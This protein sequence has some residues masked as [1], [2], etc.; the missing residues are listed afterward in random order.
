MGMRQQTFTNYEGFLDKF[1]PKK[2]TDDC[3]TP[4]NV[5]E[6]VKAWAVAEYGLE[7]REIVRPFWPGKD[8]EMAEYP[9]G[10]VVID[11]PP[12]SIL[13]KIVRWFNA[14]K[15]DYFLFA[16]YLTNFSTGELC[17]HI[18]APCSVRYANG[19]EIPTSF[20]TNLGEC[21][22]RTAPSLM[23]AIA[24]ANAENLD[25]K[26]RVLPKY[27]YPAEVITS[28]AVGQLCSHGY[29]FS[30]RR[31]ECVHIRSLDAQGDRTLF[32]AGFLMSAAKA[33][34]REAAEREAAEREAA[35]NEMVWKLSP[36]E[37]EVVKMLGRRQRR[38]E[39]ENANGV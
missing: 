38:D 17:N 29:E 2:T 11:N 1:V 27:R 28:A 33:A 31:D 36:R 32:G 21:I 7:G 26:P 13:S 22:I 18:I 10:C 37:R 12:F 6:A 16:P 14:Q 3:Y 34:E 4:A 8:Y 23:E 20:V 39:I 35:V 9:A 15:I 24:A 25:E 30:V 19:A 5:Y